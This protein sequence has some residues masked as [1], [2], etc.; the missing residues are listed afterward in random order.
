M[1]FGVQSC[2][3]Q[4]LVKIPSTEL[5]SGVIQNTSIDLFN[6]GI[7]TLRNISVY[8]SIPQTDGAVLTMQ[9]TQINEI[10]A[11]GSVYVKESTYILRNASQTFPVN[12]T[13]NYYNNSVLGQVSNQQ[14]FL[15]SGIIDIS[16]SSIT[17]SPETP[18]PGSIFSASFVL[19]DVGTASASAVSATALPKSGISPFGSNTTFI[20]D[21]AIDSQTPVTLTLQASKT[22]AYGNYTIPVMITY[23]NALRQNMSTMIYIPIKI[24]SNTS[25]SIGA[26]YAGKGT[27]TGRHGGGI[28][29]L[30]L[31][32]LVIV[33]AVL[34]YRERKARHKK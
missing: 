28:F 22:L 21:M 17:V 31:I 7:T 15:S 27:P 14:M 34:L 12:I 19:T 20:G 4:L 11:K 16:P 32:I 23:L 6:N 24:A 2:P 5:I 30:L 18:S 26:A 25:V 33:L 3:S 10:P 13:V 1:S 9:P 8:V 29:V